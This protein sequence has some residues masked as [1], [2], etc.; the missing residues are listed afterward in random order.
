MPIDPRLAA[1][2][3][4]QQTV[5]LRHRRGKAFAHSILH[6]VADH[7]GQ[8][9]CE[10]LC[11]IEPVLSFAVEKTTFHFDAPHSCTTGVSP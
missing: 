8:I 5:A 4:Q 2:D 3:G 7:T 6:A 1:A 11:I 10:M 9:A